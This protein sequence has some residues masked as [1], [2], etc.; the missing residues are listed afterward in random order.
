MATPTHQP[1]RWPNGP[2]VARSPHI[3]TLLLI[4]IALALSL[5]T[6]AA[7]T[8]PPELVGEW[9]SPDA[10]FSRELLTKGGALYLRDNG[11]AAVFGAPPP[12][13]MAGTASYDPKTFTLSLDLRDRGTP[14]AVL[15][16][17]IIFDPKAKTLTT[18]P[19]PDVQKGT[20]TRRG[21]TIP[22][23]VIDETK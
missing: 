21:K 8:I 5:R 2:R 1:R 10:R 9:V 15:K 6:F 23:W 22:K 3:K 13:G 12:I 17:T 7:D 14:T 20:F 19:T 16:L 11:F 4:V 18:K